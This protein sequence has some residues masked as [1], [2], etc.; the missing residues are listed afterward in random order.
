MIS[1]SPIEQIMLSRNHGRLDFPPMRN[2]DIHRTVF[3]VRMSPFFTPYITTRDTFDR[4]SKKRLN[5]GFGT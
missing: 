5:A 4:G 3:G 1:K 2:S